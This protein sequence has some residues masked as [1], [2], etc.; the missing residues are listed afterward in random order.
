MKRKL[1]ELDVAALLSANEEGQI[2]IPCGS[3][4]EIEAFHRSLLRLENA[5]YVSRSDGKMFYRPFVLTG[6]GKSLKAEF[7]VN[8]DQR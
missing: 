1:N 7:L 3:A 4:T 2:N 8:S 6:D 5:G